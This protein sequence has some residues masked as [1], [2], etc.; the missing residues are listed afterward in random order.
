MGMKLSGRMGMGIK[1]DCGNGMGWNGKEVIGMAG[2]WN[3]NT[4]TAHLY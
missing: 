1:C 3:Q 2:N 4:V